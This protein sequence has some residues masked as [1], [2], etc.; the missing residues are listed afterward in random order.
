MT[1]AASPRRV[2][3]LGMIA[4]ER[5][6]IR[7]C[8]KF[9]ILFLNSNSAFGLTVS[10][11][12][13]LNFIFTFT[14]FAGWKVPHVVQLLGTTSPLSSTEVISHIETMLAVNANIARS[15]RALFLDPYNPSANGARLAALACLAPE[16]GSVTINRR[17]S[18]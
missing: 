7:R 1:S 13:T 9:S 14:S 8:A 15:V 5:A 18:Y 6:A 4:E 17:G 10:R 3:E 11:P 16:T 12:Y 2:A